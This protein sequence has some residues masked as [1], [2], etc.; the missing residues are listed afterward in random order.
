MKQSSRLGIH[1]RIDKS[2]SKVLE[3]ALALGLTSCQFFFV[4]HTT[5]KYV[6][7]TNSDQKKFLALKEECTSVVAHSSYWINPAT[8]NTYSAQASK[9]LLK[10]EIT[11]AKKLG[12]PTIVLHAG[13]AKGFPTHKK[14]PF[15]HQQG[16]KAVASLINEVLKKETDIT[17]L[18]ENTAHG[19]KAICSD[20]NDFVTLRPMIEKTEQVKFCFDTAHAFSYG[21]DIAATES[22]VTLLDKTMGLKNIALLHMNDSKKES[23]S[24]VDQHALPGQGLIGT[25]VL[26][27]LINHP[28]LEHIPLIIEP[29]QE[30][31]EVL[32]HYFSKGEQHVD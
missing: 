5:G 23:G 18:I 7:L 1:L 29:P 12:I 10:K 28:Q 2:Y 22:L 11:L 8:G 15:N 20:L 26:N 30:A 6:T 4:A 13:N 17:L 32:H 27:R 31:Y 14:D 24:K 16:I 9:G 3:Q 25:Q 19:N 21:Y